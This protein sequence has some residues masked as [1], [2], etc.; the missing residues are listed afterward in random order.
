MRRFN[1]LRL[2][3][4]PSMNTHRRSANLL[5]HPVFRPPNRSCP[6]LTD[7]A[8]YPLWGIAQT[9]ND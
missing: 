3:R 4:N 7:S 9:E 8:H 6:K 1:Q 5:S 2:R